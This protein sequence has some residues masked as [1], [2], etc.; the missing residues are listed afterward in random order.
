MTPEEYFGAV[1]P[2]VVAALAVAL[3]ECPE[4]D[5]VIVST[6]DGDRSHVSAKPRGAVV[7]A[8]RSLGGARYVE[9]ADRIAQPPRY[10]L[11]RWVVLMT[12]EFC[13]STSVALVD[14][15]TEARA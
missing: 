15:R 5:V 10:P 14:A 2:L 4:A 1:R 13:A 6:R 8:L 11:A 12:P 3:A 9:T 7:D